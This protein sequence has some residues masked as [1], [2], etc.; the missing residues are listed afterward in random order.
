MIA[1]MND[2]E[3]NGPLIMP[4]GCS[5]EEYLIRADNTE[6]KRILKDQWNE[7]VSGGSVHCTCGLQRALPLAYKCLYCGVYFCARCAEKHFGKTIKDWI[8]EKRVKRRLEIQ[9][10]N[11]PIAPVM[12][13]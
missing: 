13:E 6:V 11:T 10:Y 4:L 5:L 1:A 3:I 2:T 12:K 9:G 8:Y 7:A